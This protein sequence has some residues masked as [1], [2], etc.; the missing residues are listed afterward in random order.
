[1]P[2]TFKTK[3]KRPTIVQN[4]QVS[5]ASLVTRARYYGE[6]Q[7]GDEYRMP[8]WLVLSF[9]ASEPIQHLWGENRPFRYIGDPMPY[10]ALIPIMMAFLWMQKILI[11][12]QKSK[13]DSITDLRCRHKKVPSK[14]G[15]G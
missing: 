8:S 13:L 6:V 14:E 1:M 12:P 11:R 2:D 4:S 7:A 5:S 10:W 9:T 3:E 15:C